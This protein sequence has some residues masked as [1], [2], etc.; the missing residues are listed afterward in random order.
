MPPTLPAPKT[1]LL[2]EDQP[3]TREA[4]AAVLRSEGYRVV[5]A[6]SGGE[7]TR[8]VSAGPLPNLILLDTRLPGAAGEGFLERRRSD[9]ALSAVPLVLLTE[10]N[11]GPEW[12]GPLRPAGALCKPVSL[13]GLLSLIETLA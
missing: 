13:D 4:L 2:V 6:A 7:A 8:H 9:A 1:L 11:V 3:A 10:A 5:T 12:A